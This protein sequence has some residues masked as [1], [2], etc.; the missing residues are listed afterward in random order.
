MKTEEQDR[1]LI[2]SLAGV[3]RRHGYEGASMARLAEATGLQKSSLYHRF[4]DGKRQMAREVVQ[5]TGAVFQAEVLE[6]LSAPGSPALRLQ[7]ASRAIRSFYDKGRMPCVLDSLS[8][9]DSEDPETLTL[10]RDRLTGWIE[11]FAALARESGAP[12]ADAK[13]RAMQAVAQIE[14]GLILARVTGRPAPLEQAIT[15]LPAILGL[16]R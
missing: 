3:F 5:H 13:A 1:A 4:P 6:T 12:R 8:L 11:A 10:M 14:G 7:R 15:L 16:A 9:S 2:Q